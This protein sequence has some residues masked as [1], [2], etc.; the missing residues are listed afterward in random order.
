MAFSWIPSGC[1]PNFYSFHCWY[2]F[3]PT[4]RQWEN[5]EFSVESFVEPPENQPGKKEVVTD[6]LHLPHADLIF[7]NG[8]KRCSIDRSKDGWQLVRIGPFNHPNTALAQHCDW[9]MA[10]AHYLKAQ[11][12][13][14]AR[15]AGLKLIADSGGAQIK[16]RIANYVDP[17]KVITAYN[18]CADYGMALDVPPRPGVDVS[19]SNTLTILARIQ[20]K[21]NELF[22]A[23]R[24]PDLGLLNVVHG[25]RTNDIRLWIDIVKDELNFQGWAIGLDFDIPGVFRAAAIL[26]R[27]YGLKESG[28]WLHLFGVSG[29]TQIPAMAWLGKYVPLLTADSSSFLEGARRRTYFLNNGGK[30]KSLAL[31]TGKFCNFADMAYSDSSLLPC[32]CEFCNLT[33]YFGAYTTKGFDT[34][35]S[36]IIAHNFVVL[37]QVA[38]QWNTLAQQLDLKSYVNLVRSRIGSTA[39][40]LCEYVDA[41]LNSG[42]DEA[43]KQFGKFLYD[44]GSMHQGKV[45]E[46]VSRQKTRI[47]L[48]FTKSTQEDVIL[49][50]G[51]PGSNIEVIGNYLSDAE[52][53]DVYKEFGFSA[54][55]QDMISKQKLEKHEVNAAEDHTV[56]VIQEDGHVTDVDFK[57][58]IELVEE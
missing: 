55:E 5:L 21:N 50:L 36:M 19:N 23:K 37:K 12:G 9:V 45:E 44:C 40:I 42:P 28:Q 35:F 16:F 43:S 8:A 38:A 56:P 39:S 7:D 25:T 29:P 32:C 4:H 30:V 58:P 51:T 13:N 27:E 3:K 41:C 46:R 54:A 6:I 49:G 10:S 17:E 14:H 34:A 57:E 20:K 2:K 22:A 33:K 52:L 47:P 53:L 18:N 31:G 48:F 26:Y 24:R 15:A 11:D 1:T